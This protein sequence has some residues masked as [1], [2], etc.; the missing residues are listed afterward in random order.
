MASDRIVLIALPLASVAGAS[1]TTTA[2]ALVDANGVDPKKKK[3]LYPGTT[4]T[5]KRCMEVFTD[6][7]FTAIDEYERR[8]LPEWWRAPDVGQGFV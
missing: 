1:Q 2:L 5:Q 7:E 4:Q 6:D 3:A 8:I